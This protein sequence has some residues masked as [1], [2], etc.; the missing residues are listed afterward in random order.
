MRGH[1]VDNRWIVPYNPYVLARYNCHINVECSV[2]FAS[3]K[4]IS[5][6]IHKGHDCATIE[7]RVHDEIKDYLDSRF[8][9]AP[10][11]IWRLYHFDLHEQSPP[12]IRLQIHLPGQHLVAFNPSESPEAVLERAAQERTMLTA[13]FEANADPE[14]G[15][16]ACKY[17][18]QEFPQYFVWQATQKRWTIRKHGFALGRMYFVSVNAGDRYYLRLLLTVV[19]GP[20]SFEHLRTVNG[21][22]HPTY[23]A[24][25]VALGLLEDDGE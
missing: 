23:R 18:Y 22:V 13:F 9:A 4:Y 8:V 1:A 5:K 2:T 17:T 12:V 24:A 3:L 21:V 19:R 11:A 14:L 16:T 20:M 6:Y 10:E 15:Q 7:V 25:C